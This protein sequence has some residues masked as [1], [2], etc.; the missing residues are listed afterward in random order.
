MPCI[1][2]FVYVP[3]FDGFVGL[4]NGADEFWWLANMLC[5]IVSKHRTT[6]QPAR[7]NDYDSWRNFQTGFGGLFL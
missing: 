6:P 1:A 3:V 5:R 7:R 2:G 4:M